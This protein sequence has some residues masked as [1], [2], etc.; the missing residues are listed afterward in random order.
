MSTTLQILGAVAITTGAALIAIP[1]GF[2]IGGGL[3]ILIG[4]AM[5]K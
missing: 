4:F 3:L 1:L 2:V 5:G